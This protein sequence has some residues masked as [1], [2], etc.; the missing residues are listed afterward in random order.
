MTGAPVVRDREHLSARSGVEASGRVG[1]C[2]LRSAPAA[3]DSALGYAFSRTS[4]DDAAPRR[5]RGA[6]A[7][8]RSDKRNVRECRG[9]RAITLACELHA[10]TTTRTHPARGSEGARR[11]EASV[12]WCR[13]TLRVPCT[14]GSVNDYEEYDGCY[15]HRDEG[16]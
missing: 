7:R 1:A 8:R 16:C 12:G 11:L 4:R 2:H 6:R 15:T 10:C 3:G 9:A 5:R 14:D 13:E